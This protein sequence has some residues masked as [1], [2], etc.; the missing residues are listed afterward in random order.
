MDENYILNPDSFVSGMNAYLFFHN[1]YKN[2]HYIRSC[3]RH[4][5]DA[6]TINVFMCPGDLGISSMSPPARKL[7]AESKFLPGYVVANQS[8]PRLAPLSAVSTSTTRRSD[9]D[10]GVDNVRNASPQALLDEIPLRN[11]GVFF[12]PAN[13]SRDLVNDSRSASPTPSIV[14]NK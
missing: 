13:D 2:I 9:D 10:D 1:I 14:S 7:K 8:T 4:T 11:L 5:V 3:K 6:C 12:D